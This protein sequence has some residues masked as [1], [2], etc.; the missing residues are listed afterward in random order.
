MKATWVKMKF[1][2][3]YRAWDDVHK[4]FDATV[5]ANLL[6]QMHD[7]YDYL[8]KEYGKRFFLDVW[9]GTIDRNKRKIFTGDIVAIWDEVNIDKF[10]KTDVIRTVEYDDYELGF[11]A[12]TNGG[13]VCKCTKGNALQMEVIGNIYETKQ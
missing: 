11:I 9:I 4:Q 1:P 3:C 10:V 12:V 5:C 13:D 2:I 8:D 7:P 6:Q